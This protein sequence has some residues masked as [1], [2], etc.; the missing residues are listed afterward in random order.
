MGYWRNDLLQIS[1]KF[2]ISIQGGKD[3]YSNPREDLPDNKTYL[4]YE[5]ALLHK[6]YRSPPLWSL[7][8]PRD[9]FS[10]FHWS[11]NFEPGSSPV[12]GYLSLEEIQEIIADVLRVSKIIHFG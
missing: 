8:Q 4:E 5:V 3:C 1:P 2:A 9:Y 12:A 10:N 11:S 7:F 6:N